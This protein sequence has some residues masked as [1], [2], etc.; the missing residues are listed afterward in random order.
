MKIYFAGEPGG[1]KREREEVLLSYISHRLQSYVYQ[2]Q[3]I[4]TIQVIN[5]R[6]FLS[7]K[8]TSK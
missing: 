3:F 1:N 8:N 4:L 2:D 7:H 6:I 5:E